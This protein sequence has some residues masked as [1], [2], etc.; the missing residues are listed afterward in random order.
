MEEELN[1]IL[2]RASAL[3]EEINE[4]YQ[5]ANR[6]ELITQ[7]RDDFESYL[8]EEVNPLLPDD[9][10]IQGVKGIAFSLQ[11]SGYIIRT[12]VLENGETGDTRQDYAMTGGGPGT[13]GSVFDAS[14]RYKEE[15]D[16][17]ASV[18]LGFRVPK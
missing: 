6:E 14:D 1:R 16:H 15:N 13:L 12:G 7:V 11:Q 5:Q 17:V 9:W 3:D 18:Q 2:T 8:E 4:F 10:R